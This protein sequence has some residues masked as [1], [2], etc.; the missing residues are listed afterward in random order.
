MCVLD[1]KLKVELFPYR[2]IF[3][4]SYLTTSYNPCFIH[5]IVGDIHFRALVFLQINSSILVSNSPVSVIESPVLVF[6]MP[7]SVNDML[8]FGIY[9]TRFGILWVRFGVSVSFGPFRSVS[10][11][12]QTIKGIIYPFL[13]RQN[14]DTFHYNQLCMYSFCVRNHKP[15]F[16]SQLIYFG[17][18][19]GCFL[20][21]SISQRNQ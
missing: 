21:G 16:E 9:Y 12:R 19:Y 3:I 4:L 11:I 5:S 20:Q 13:Y 14:F 15:E 18:K 2:F 6:I 8:R 7:V 10:M 17:F 1:I